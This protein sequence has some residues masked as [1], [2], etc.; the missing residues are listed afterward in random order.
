MQH[1]IDLYPGDVRIAMPP[2]RLRSPALGSCVAVALYDI[3]IG[4]GGM[5]HVMLPSTKH[6]S[7]GSDLLKYA[8]QAIPYLIKK[9][10]EFGASRKEI[11]ARLVGGAMM[12]EGIMN[13]GAM[14]IESVEDTLKCEG[15]E[16]TGRRLGGNVCRTSILDIATGTLWYTEDNGEER[17]L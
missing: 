12:V 5:A 17:V 13:I 10:V 16:I 6:Y 9:M 14:V 1:S 3:V 4:V 7:R 8:D 11:R 2:T 15:I